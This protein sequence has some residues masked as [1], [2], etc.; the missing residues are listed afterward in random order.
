[1]LWVEANW[2]M[3]WTVSG[4]QLVTWNPLALNRANLPHGGG[5]AQLQ[6]D[7]MCSAHFAAHPHLPVTVVKLA[8]RPNDAVIGRR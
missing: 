6:S 1:M 8:V 3:T 2:V 7:P 4:D 5:F